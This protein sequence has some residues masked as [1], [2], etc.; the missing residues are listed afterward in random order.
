[1]RLQQP[2]TQTGDI[3]IAP[4]SRFAMLVKHVLRVRIGKQ[5][6]RAGITQFVAEAKCKVARDYPIRAR[7]ARWQ[8]GAAHARDAPLG[9]SNRALLF[10][11]RGC[12]QQHIRVGCRFDSRKSILH[13]DELGFDQRLMHT[14]HVGHRLR[15]IGASDPHCFDGSRMQGI[16]EFH[17]GFARC[18][19]H[20]RH[21]PQCR[22]FRAMRRVG[23]IA[24][25]RQQIRHTAD[26][27]SAHRIGLTGQRQRPCAGLADLPRGEMQIDQ[28]GI[29]VRAVDRLIKALAI[30]RQ[31]RL[32]PGE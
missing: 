5:A 1:M 26:F 24:M 14:R 28:R 9:I 21:A 30:Q 3:Q 32:R 29:V 20:S 16:K 4:A 13:H 12:G 25:R 15:R 27:A 6:L 8:H 31:R 19:R 22:H 23:K 2:I 11:P 10:A 7:L 17:R 18:G